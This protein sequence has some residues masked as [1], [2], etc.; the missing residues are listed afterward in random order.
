M[1]ADWYIGGYVVVMLLLL[2][3]FISVWWRSHP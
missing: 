2:A 3:W 1:T